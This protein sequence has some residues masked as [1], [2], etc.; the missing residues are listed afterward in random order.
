M[1]IQELEYNIEGLTENRTE[2]QKGR[3]SG[4]KCKKE[5]STRRPRI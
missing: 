1:K 5:D 3:K 4:V 2:K